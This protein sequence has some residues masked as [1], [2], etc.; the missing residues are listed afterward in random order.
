MKPQS[1]SIW[2]RVWRKMEASVLR[3]PT[4]WDGCVPVLCGTTNLF[5]CKVE[6]GRVALEYLFIYDSFSTDNPV[7]L[8]KTATR[9]LNQYVVVAVLLYG[10]R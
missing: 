7:N 6:L 8:H 10:T 3:V 9:A 2:P 5:L 1:I 4:V